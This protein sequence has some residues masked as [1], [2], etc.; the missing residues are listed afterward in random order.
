MGARRD[1]S[2]PGTSAG[3]RRSRRIGSFRARTRQ[4]GPP[5]DRDFVV[6]QRKHVRQRL[7]SPYADP[8]SSP[9][10]VAHG[11]VLLTENVA[12][13]ARIAAEHLSTGQHHHGVL[14]ALSS[15]FSRRRAGL[16]RLVDA[17]RAVAAEAL[18]DRLVYLQH[19]DHG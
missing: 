13:F 19:A 2:R 3:L 12:D 10:R 1:A 14:I 4:I 16:N 5:T 7:G 11:Y 9:Q 6:L 8:I 17:V 18:E 15:R